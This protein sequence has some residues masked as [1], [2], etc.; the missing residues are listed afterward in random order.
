MLKNKNIL[1]FGESLCNELDKKWTKEQEII[2][3]LIEFNTVY[4]I[5]RMGI[6]SY[7]F[8]Y[9]IKGIFKR[10]K[11]FFYRSSITQTKC[12]L[13]LKCIRLL[14]IPINISLFD[15]LNRILLIN[16]IKWKLKIKF[17]KNLIVWIAY[18]S[19]YISLMLETL[20]SEIFVIYQCTDRHKYKEGPNSPTYKA[21]IQITKKADMVITPSKKILQDK[22]RFNSNI[23]R[24]PH[25]ATPNIISF[26]KSNIDKKSTPNIKFNDATICYYGNFHR[27]FDFDL[28]C[29]NAIQYP[30]YKFILWGSITKEARKKFEKFPNII[31]KG[32]LS[33]NHV[34]EKLIECDVCIIPY[35][36]NEFS[37]GVFPHKFFTYLA[38]GRPIV[39]TKLPDLEDFKD[40]VFLA[41]NKK[42]FKLFLKEAVKNSKDPIY[43]SKRFNKVS[44]FLKSHSSKKYL[45]QLHEFIELNLSE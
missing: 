44:E 3:W 16:Q 42:E 26:L 39:S 6:A 21:D 38:S 30:H 4:F 19:K 1:W 32:Y 24:L 35:I 12:N 9:I 40:W 13:T 7:S 23:F 43:M 14:L 34:L 45:N 37:T 8:L 10:I 36:L 22:Q 17:N 2:S 28:V 18:P 20:A 11:D 31:L 33:H 29:Q 41:K 27:V 15:K 5:E 25:Y